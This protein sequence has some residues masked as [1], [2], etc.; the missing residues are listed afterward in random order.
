MSQN[1]NTL[2]EAEV[3]FTDTGE[4]AGLELA[5]LK[6]WE[7]FKTYFPSD[8]ERIRAVTYSE[9]PEMLDRVFDRIDVG[10]ME[11]VVGD[12]TKDYRE[13]LRGKEQL[14]ARLER[15][16]REGRLRIVLPS[17]K[18]NEVHS[19]LYLL[20][21]EDGT[22]TNIV[23]S[24]NFSKKAWESAYQKNVI[25]V[26]RTSGDQRL[27]AVFDEWYEEMREY[28]KVFMGDLTERI[29][30]LPDEEQ[31]EEVHAWIAG[32]T[33]SDSEEAELEQ[34]LTDQ[35][36][37]A[38]VTTATIVGDYEEE[39][40]DLTVSIADDEEESDVH[41]SQSLQGYESVP[42]DWQDDF[43]SLDGTI[44]GTK[45]RASP[46]AVSRHAKETFGA[47][48]M[49]F[50]DDDRLV[51]QTPS[52]LQL[53][54]M[55]EIPDDP[56]RIARAFDHLHEYFDAVDKFGKTDHERAVKAQMYEAIIWFFWA[57]FINR[58]ARVYKNRGIDLDKFLPSLYIYGEPGSGKGTLARYAFHMLSD[59]HVS[60]P[61]D[62]DALNTT[63]LRSVR[64][65]DSTF[66]VVFDDINPSDIDT[67]AYLNFRQKHW[68]G[69][70]D[71]PALAFIS[72]DNLPRS[73]IQHR[74]KVLHLDVQFKQ[75]HK[76]AE[77]AS[78][79]TERSNPL[80]TWFAREFRDREIAIREEDDDT[81]AEA[82]NVLLDLYERA[83]REPPKYFPRKP[84]EERYDMGK[85]L[86]QD[87]VE[88]D[89]VEFQHRNG[90]LVAKFDESLSV[91]S[92]AREYARSLPNGARA[93]N[94]GHHVIIKDE[95]AVKD[96]F[97]FDIDRGGFLS[98]VLP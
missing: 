60:E 87:A 55:R 6:R 23:G 19:K 17:L 98:R 46:G 56:D 37:E 84:A 95:D 59:G 73:R 32:R 62:G 58:Y 25:V 51:L 79:L 16:Q 90:K 61:E 26:F 81:L 44:E 22:R 41:I 53:D 77:Y 4:H 14:A 34:A 33:T 94:D 88:S 70:A 85:Y 21:H 97:P 40:A 15:L 63:T 68:T 13:S 30:E 83:G 11:V 43:R 92:S 28:G 52:D 1:R 7:N 74:A 27:D 38:N 3:E 5:T 39:E 9:S 69:E 91:Y 96:W 93:G 65:V 82:R 80:F 86:W 36:D 66:P 10:E 45:L 57:P 50:T 47:P 29:K 89:L 42:Q 2:L 54:L 12:S 31:E 71:F 75:T 8:I 72:N 64:K 48:K 76:T 78:N 67:E 24:P 35:L 49:W 18:N 20:D